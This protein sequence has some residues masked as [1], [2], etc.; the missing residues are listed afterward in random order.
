[1]MRPLTKSEWNMIYAIASMLPLKNQQQLLFD[2]EFATAHSV[3]PD[4][5]LLKFSI[6]GYKRPPYVGQHSFGVEGE[7]LDRDG[8]RVS[9]I[10]F[11][12]QNDRLSEL[13]LIRWGEGDLIEPD[14]G[15]LKLY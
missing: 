12:D 5:S 7:L 2:L 8:T 15:T 13:E 4:N 10:L 11:A 6:A 1:M 9:L 14:W 3:L